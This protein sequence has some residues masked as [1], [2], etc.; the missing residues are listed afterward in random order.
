MRDLNQL[1]ECREL[2]AAHKY[3]VLSKSGAIYNEIREYLKREDAQVPHVL[4]LIDRACTLPENRG[5]VCN[6]FLHIWGHFKK[7]A[8]AEEKADF[9]YRLEQYRCGQAE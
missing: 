1:K 4:S 3:F 8:C 5:Q 9:L 2:W 6:A 7:K